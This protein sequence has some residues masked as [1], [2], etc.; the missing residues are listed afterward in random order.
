MAD[1][2]ACRRGRRRPT[3]EL[4]ATDVAAP[5][6]FVTTQFVRAGV[7]DAH[8]DLQLDEAVTRASGVRGAG[9]CC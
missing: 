9:Q 5:I 7:P 4:A 2:T 6:G 8:P 3:R 1:F